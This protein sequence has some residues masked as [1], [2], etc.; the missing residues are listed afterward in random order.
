ML[1]QYE[2]F[3]S[4][5]DIQALTAALERPLLP[6]VR[7]NRL[8]IDDLAQQI[9]TYADRFG[10]E[11]QPLAFCEAGWQLQTF[12]QSPGQTL[13]HR[14]GMYYVQDPA[15]MIAAEMFDHTNLE[16]PLILDMAAAPGGKTTHLVS[17]FND[18]GA[19]VANDSSKKRITALRA[20][21]Q[22]WGAMGAMVTNYPGEKLGLW[23][24]ETFDAVLLDA[25][26]SGDTL[27][28][29]KGRK[30]RDVSDAERSG[31]VQRQIALLT[32][33][34]YATQIGG[35]IVYSTCTMNPD[36]NEG[37]MTAMLR[38]FP[39]E[40]EAVENLPHTGIQADQFHPAVT[41]ATRLW[42][43]LF[44]TSGFFAARLRKTSHIAPPTTDEPPLRENIAYVTL[45]TRD[46]NLICDNVQSDYGFDFAATIDQLA[47]VLLQKDDLVY[48]VPERLLSTFD[49]L[50]S[51]SM[52][53]LIGQMVEKQFLPSHELVS[54]FWS[55]FQQQR[56]LLHNPN[57]QHIW[58]SGR[59]L[60]AFQAMNL[61]KGSI[62]LL[63]NEFGEFIGRGKLLPKRIR[64]LLP[65][66]VV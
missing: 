61:P 23:F 33:A 43:H 54:R 60:R 48:A 3:L 16:S 57:E 30:K 24:P 63:E 37:V 55:G 18:L 29:E 10:W 25:P 28:E 7:L 56:M 59:D 40:I 64:N 26:C 66:R 42:P 62:I 44:Q 21:L 51:M 2:N 38:D 39:L 13:P 50:P 52:G 19:V 47:L 49:D 5:K 41:R 17:R 14:M 12:D 1:G 27:R 20:N 8:K 6:G 34:F 58:L 45:S 32:S 11:P 36:E 15:S 31:L 9:Q 46:V 35:E 22:S 4:T 65:K 53:L